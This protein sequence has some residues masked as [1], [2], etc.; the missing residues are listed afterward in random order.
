MSL[1]TLVCD[2]GPVIALAK[3]DRLELPHDLG[4]D[5]L[6]PQVVLYEVLAKPGA[7]AARMFK[8]GELRSLRKNVNFKTALRVAERLP[9]SLRLRRTSLRLD[10][11]DTRDS[12]RSRTIKA[13]GPQLRGSTWIRQLELPQKAQKA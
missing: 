12:R 1:K 11:P 3:I 2:A 8:K 6:I 10:T 13:E 9:S 4:S 5:V 7:D